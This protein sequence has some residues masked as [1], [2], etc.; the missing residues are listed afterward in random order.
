MLFK[1]H[2]AERYSPLYLLAALGAGGMAVAFYL[3]LMFLTPHPD[4]PVPTWDS[5]RIFWDGADSLARI[6]IGTAWLATLALIVLHVLLLLWNVREYRIFQ[7][8][9]AYQEL[10]QSNATFQRMAWPLTLAMSMNAGFVAALLLI[11]GF[12]SVIERIFPWAIAAFAVLGFS[13]LRLQTSILGEQLTRGGFQC[14]KNNNLGMMMA[15]FALAMISVGSSGPAAMS[16]TLA[17]SLIATALCWVFLVMAVL[18]ALVYV[19]M[20]MRALFAQGA[21]DDSS[22]TLMVGVPISTVLGIAGYRLAMMLQH[23]FNAD[24]PPIVI[25]LGFLSVLNVQLM[26]VL[27]GASILL[28]N[29]MLWKALSNGPTPLSFALVC[30][31]VGLVV[32]LMFLIHRGLLPVVP[33]LASLVPWLTALLVLAQ[34]GLLAAYTNMVKHQLYSLPPHPGKRKEMA[35]NE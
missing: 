21:S 8:T 11:P 20:S 15:P 33:E 6:G 17:T 3:H 25:L 14:E 32:T 13:A 10:L 24:I 34:I 30:P 35:G 5:L 1:T 16:K 28:R 26:F 22:Q 27:F 4:S 19:L 31:G 23:H 2:L 12:W 9:P 29:R 7:R 18:A